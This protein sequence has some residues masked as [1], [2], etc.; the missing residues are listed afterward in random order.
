MQ[1]I[2][3][4]R[5]IK[6]ISMADTEIIEVGKRGVVEIAPYYENGEMASV[7][8]FKVIGENKDRNRPAARVNGKYVTEIL[9]A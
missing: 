7:L 8:W 1:I 5:N 4:S 6:L 2:E 3:D 9:Y